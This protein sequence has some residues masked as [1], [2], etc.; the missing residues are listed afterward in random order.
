[1]GDPNPVL[2]LRNLRMTSPFVR[3]LR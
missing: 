2:N 3:T 1:M